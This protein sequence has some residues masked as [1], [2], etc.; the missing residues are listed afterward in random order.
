[1]DHM[2]NPMIEIKGDKATEKQITN[3]RES[4]VIVETR[5]NLTRVLN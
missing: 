4:I 3:S 5:T 2:L 1:M